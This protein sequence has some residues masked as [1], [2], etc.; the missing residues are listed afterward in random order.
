MKISLKSLKL[1]SSF[2]IALSLSITTFSCAAKNV[3]KQDF[4]EVVKNMVPFIK[5]DGKNFDLYLTDINGSYKTKLTNDAFEKADPVVTPGGKVLFTSKRTG[6]WQLYVVNPDGTDLKQLTFD[7]GFN[8]YRPSVTIDGNVIFVSDR[9]VKPKIFVMEP[10]GENLIKLTEDDNYYDFP[11]PLDDGSI[12]YLSNEKSKWEI[13]K[14]NADGSNK[15]KITSIPSKPLSLTTIPGYFKDYMRMIPTPDDS[16]A[17][18]REQGLVTFMPKAIFSA[19]DKN[20]DVEIFRINIDGTD[21]R[22]LTQMPGYDSEPVAL[23][24]GKIAF[25]SDRDGIRDVWVMEPDGYN[26]MNITKDPYYA[27]TR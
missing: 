5:K 23:R 10:N 14:M 22:N 27:S 4:K 20:G 6:T 24:S 1:I 8:N 18:R 11:S 12:L 16:F 7:K 2:S 26:P 15:R 17:V 21:L 19:R 9:E 25:S 13:W 3:K